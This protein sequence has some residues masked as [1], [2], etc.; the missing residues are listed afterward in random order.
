MFKRL[1]N[2]SIFAALINTISRKSEMETVNNIRWIEG[3]IAGKTFVLAGISKSEKYHL[4]KIYIGNNISRT[5]VKEHFPATE[6]VSEMSSII[7][8]SGIDLVIIP[9]QQKDEL[10]LVAEILQTGKNIRIV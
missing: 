10:N 6:I 1:N 8:D 5:W 9:A 4:K 3:S 7:D 2:I